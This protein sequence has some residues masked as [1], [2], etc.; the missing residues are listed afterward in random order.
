MRNSNDG[1]D[2]HLNCAIQI[3]HRYVILR[4]H[5]PKYRHSND[6][7]NWAFRIIIQIAHF[8]SRLNTVGQPF[9]LKNN[10]LQPLRT[11]TPAEEVRCGRFSPSYVI[12]ALPFVVVGGSVGLGMVVS[13]RISD[14]FPFPP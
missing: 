3:T 5:G 1:L 2:R 12:R 6:D 13:S 9:P 10:P 4:T 14:H 7:S 11:K 8:C